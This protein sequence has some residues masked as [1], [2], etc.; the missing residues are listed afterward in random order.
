[1]TFPSRSYDL[2]PSPHNISSPIHHSEESPM[3]SSYTHSDPG[4]TLCCIPS[5][6]I[7]GHHILRDTPPETYPLY[8]FMIFPFMTI[9]PPIYDISSPPPLL[10]T[11]FPPILILKKIPY[12]YFPKY[13]LYVFSILYENALRCSGI[14][15][16]SGNL[17]EYRVEMP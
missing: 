7:S 3:S 16:L 2:S 17:P 10:M 4:D 12:M 9:P 6:C 1:M 11:Q 15:H 8:L 13:P 5:P 14:M